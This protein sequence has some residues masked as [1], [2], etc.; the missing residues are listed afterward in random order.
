MSNNRSIDSLQGPRKSEFAPPIL[1]H[2]KPRRRFGQHFLVDKRHLQKL[3]DLAEVNQGD[4]VLEVGAGTGNLTEILQRSAGKVIAVEKDRVLVAHLERK[5]EGKSNLQ[6]VCGDVL[7]VDLPEFDKVVSSPPYNISSALLFALMR[8][9]FKVASMILQ[10]E[11]AQ[12]L[13]ARAGT[14]EY[15]RLTI[16]LQHR[17]TAELFDFVPR[18]SFRP[19]PK[20][21]SFIV[22]IVPRKLIVRREDLFEKL[23]RILFSQRRRVAETVLRRWLENQGILDAREISSSLGITSKRVFEL[24]TEEIER[25]SRD[26]RTMKKWLSLFLIATAKLGGATQTQAIEIT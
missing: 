20:V 19:I 5:F 10:K 24:T 26:F 1:K 8:K 21:D 4:I 17:A 14:K 2:F 12:R 7:R 13:V 11:F 23:V 25:I 3:V 6:I 16:M 18:I 9:R 15:G 22:R